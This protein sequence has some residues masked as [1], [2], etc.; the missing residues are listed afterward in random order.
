MKKLLFTLVAVAVTSWA[1]AQ[2]TDA[3]VKAEDLISFKE[4]KHDFGKIKQGTPV[5]YDFAFNNISDKPVIIENAWASC[6]CTTPTK[7]EQ[8]IAKGK[9]NV[10]KAGFN[11][12]A[13]GTFD[14]TVYVKIQGID[15]PLELKITGEVLN[16]EA[17]A[18]YV[19]EKKDNKGG[20]K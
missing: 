20:S 18:K 17:Y 13:A 11:A 19:A 15:I 5:T 9:S 4:K 7:P 10:I 16:A 3:K 1:V 2:N 14:K 8:P 12:A 6:G